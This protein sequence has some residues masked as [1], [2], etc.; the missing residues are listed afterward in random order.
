MMY[1]NRWN[2]REIYSDILM[3][4]FHVVCQNYQ[5]VLKTNEKI[6]YYGTC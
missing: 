3:V 5:L 1:L 6:D 4:K 2:Q